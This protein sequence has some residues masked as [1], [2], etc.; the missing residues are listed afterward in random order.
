L[1][2]YAKRGRNKTTV[3]KKKKNKQLSGEDNGAKTF[4]PG[5]GV[6]LSPDNQEMGGGGP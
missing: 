2:K 6:T 5:G 1:E 3:M 4:G